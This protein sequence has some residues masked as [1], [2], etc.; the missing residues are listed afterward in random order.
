MAFSGDNNNGACENS[1]NK[2][3]ICSTFMGDRDKRNADE[4]TM[5]VQFGDGCG[6]TSGSTSLLGLN[7]DQ[8]IQITNFLE[9]RDV[10]GIS[11]TCRR[12]KHCCGQ[13]SIVDTGEVR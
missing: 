1:T 11:L 13:C 4:D 7:L 2:S 9:L 10:F 8:F 3:N 12:M 5:T 6:S